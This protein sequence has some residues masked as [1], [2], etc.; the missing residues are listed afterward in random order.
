MALLGRKRAG[1]VELA[2][3]RDLRELGS[4]GKTALGELALVLARA[5]DSRPEAMTTVAK[6]VQ[7]LRVT[8]G[9]LRE[10]SVRDGDPGEDGGD[11][12]PVWDAPESGSADV[13]SAVGG[14][15]SAAG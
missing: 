4:A 13:G 14:G 5:I 1:R 11:N 12:T 15:G 9:Q 2:V 6:L 8:L 10:L 7:E 3:R